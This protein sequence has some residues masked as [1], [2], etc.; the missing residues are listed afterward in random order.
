MSKLEK[1]IRKNFTKKSVR[2]Q[3]LKGLSKEERKIYIK[4]SQGK[5]VK[6]YLTLPSKINK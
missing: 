1:I 3:H 6:K 4:R 5:V 2:D